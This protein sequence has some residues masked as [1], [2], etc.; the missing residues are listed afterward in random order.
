MTGY[1]DI[2]MS[3]KAMKAGAIDSLTKP[4]RELDMLDSVARVLARDSERRTAKQAT[5]L[6]RSV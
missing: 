5:A 4:F 1:G 2:E 3:V 6:I